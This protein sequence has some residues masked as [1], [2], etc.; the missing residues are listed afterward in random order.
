MS[1][2]TDPRHSASS[3]KRSVPAVV[4]GSR[5]WQQ[6]LGKF[7]AR[8]GVELIIGGLVLIS[9]GLTL[10]EFTVA[11]NDGTGEHEQLVYQ[12]A[13][14]NDSVTMVFVVELALR[15]MAAR[16]KRRFFREYWIDLIAVLPLF[17]VFR[18]ARAVR[19]LRLL[20]LL[21]LF[22]VVSR[23]SIHF[24][25]VMRRG[26]V[27]YL[28]TCGMLVLTVLFATGAMMYFEGQRETATGY[29]TE[30][31]VASNNSDAAD[32][33]DVD[34]D[35]AAAFGFQDA[36]WFSVYSLFAGEPIPN[37]PRT[38][39]GKF[40]SVFVMFMGLTIFAMFTGTVSAFMVERLRM[41]GTGM[42]WDELFNHVIICG[43]NNKA[44]I[45]IREFRA[46]R[47]FSEKAVA[48]ISQFEGE[49]PQVAADLRK[50]MIF[51]NDD[52]TRIPA[53][54]QAGVH[55]ASTCII[56]SDRHGG[57]SEQD[58][59][60]RTI[61]AALTVEKLNPAVYTC[62]ELLNRS[63]GTHLQVGNV[64]DFVVS[65]E[66]GAYLLAHACMNKGM[67]GVFSE[68]MT[69]QHGNGFFRV[70]LPASWVDRPFVDVLTELKQRHEAILVAAETPQ[71]RMLVNPRD[72][73]FSAG[74]QLI[75]IAER[76]PQLG[77]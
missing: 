25:E 41:E 8:P 69:Y 9:V 75:I 43:W 15:F 64:N 46:S 2:S 5:P 27:E 59:D 53:L 50:Q 48:V 51:L 28:F 71:G 60:A 4:A 77:S 3:Q 31:D 23:L 47:G 44:E 45:I 70:P 76:E 52:F 33:S 61:L 66:Y 55:R 54:E 12:L 72:H 40:V 38:L 10:I 74:D 20:R 42:Q 37:A 56:L 1:A 17:R 30:T 63:Y 62:A 32:S 67:I 73:H 68:L 58:A 24:P 34:S 29:A 65:G 39:A 35:E 7:F 19:L 18:V 57:R 6:R 26:F 36:F 14:A 16:S 49:P 13:L 22:G 11:S 21:R